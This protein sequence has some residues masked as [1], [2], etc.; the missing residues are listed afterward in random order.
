MAESRDRILERVRQAMKSG[1]IPRSE[2]PEL[3]P[4]AFERAGREALVQR[5]VSEALAAGVHVIEAADAAAVCAE[6]GRRIRGKRVLSSLPEALPFGAGAV[7]SEAQCVAPG[8]ARADLESVEIGVTA[9]DAAIA[10][11]GTL[12][13][14]SRTEQPR[15]ASLL[16]PVHVALVRAE[17]V[18]ATLGTLFTKHRSWFD[19]SSCIQLI[20]GPSRTGDIELKLTLGVHGPCELVVLL[21]PGTE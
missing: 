6:L 21:G 8:A 16:P 9:V 5:F 7:L 15:L 10:E 2:A 1:R 17:Q 19:T 4:S 14:V 3:M 20:T 18:V 13:L 12:V 11:T